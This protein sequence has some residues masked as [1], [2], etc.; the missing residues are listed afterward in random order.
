MRTASSV[1]LRPTRRDDKHR[2]SFDPAVAGTSR[3]QAANWVHRKPTRQRPH[4]EEA[5]LEQV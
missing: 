2:A 4:V 5:G 3:K 1:V